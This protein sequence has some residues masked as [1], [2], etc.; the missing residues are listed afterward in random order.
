MVQFGKG[1]GVEVTDD[2]KAGAEE[3][4]S[5]KDREV[6]KIMDHGRAVRHKILTGNIHSVC[7]TCQKCLNKL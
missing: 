3:D 5:E 6:Q 7:Q 4:Q 1:G 2:E